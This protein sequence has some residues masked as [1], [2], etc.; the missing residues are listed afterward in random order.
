[1]AL[2]MHDAG[3]SWAAIAASL[4]V[5][6]ES[7][8]REGV[9][10]YLGAQRDSSRSAAARVA[11][12]ARWSGSPAP[13]HSSRTFGIEIEFHT[14]IRGRVVAALESVLGYRPHMTG[15]HGNRC[16]VCGNNISGYSQWKLETDAS[17]VANM[18]NGGSGPTNQ[19]GEL[20]SPVLSGQAGL[21]EVKK[22]MAALRSVGARVDQRHGMHIHLGVVDLDDTA[23]QQ[24]LD[25]YMMMQSTLYSLVAPARL[26]NRYSQ[27]ISSGQALTWR[28][29]FRRHRLP[30]GNHT[31]AF[32]VSNL[33]RIGTIEMR[34]H[35][36]SLNGKKAT[37]WIQ[38]LVALFDA[39]ANG[40]HV[41]TLNDLQL[42]GRISESDL[43]WYNNRIAQLTNQ[44]VAV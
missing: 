16:Q 34:H 29:S 6:G 21:D 33:S 4:G 31:D 36:G 25:N 14:A 42:L 5:A 9:R 7:T 26:R 30:V 23:Q 20:V 17:A 18:R 27:P 32:N 8:V 12:A 10:R 37:M 2:A 40:E 13:Q 41:Q 24:L 28:D 19:G 35:Q 39:S 38:L 11:L 44:P 3:M 1:M 15:Y 43:R 22:V